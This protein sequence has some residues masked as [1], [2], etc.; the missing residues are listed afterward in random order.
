MGA[1]WQRW[2]DKPRTLEEA[3]REIQVASPSSKIK[4]R[5][6]DIDMIPTHFGPS[7]F[8]DLNRWIARLYVRRYVDGA[9]VD[10]NPGAGVVPQNGGSRD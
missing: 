3:Y 7:V 1:G 8:S 9:W 10:W 4:A 6:S 5:V 2:W